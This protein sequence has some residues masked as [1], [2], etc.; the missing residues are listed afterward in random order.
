MEDSKDKL[1][2]AE[3]ILQEILN[4]INV[5]RLDE[6]EKNDFMNTYYPYMLL[7]KTW[8]YEFIN[9]EEIEIAEKEISMY[10]YNEKRKLFNHKLDEIY[11]DIRDYFFENYIEF[12]SIK[13]VNDE[14]IKLYRIYY[15][16]KKMKNK[17][18]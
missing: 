8:L 13:Y 18:Y 2:K 10:F 9:D 1:E 6:F 12:A 17:R 16:Y 4:D 11:T 15:S 7:L 5:Y 3:I 14:F